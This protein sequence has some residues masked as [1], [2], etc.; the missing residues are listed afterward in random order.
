MHNEFIN[1]GTS[2]I[3]L[4]EECIELN[5]EL[6]DLIKNICKGER[7][8]YDDHSPYLPITETNRKKIIEEMA[9]VENAINN[10]KAF[11]EILPVDIKRR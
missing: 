8:G 6:N 5:M 11:L 2:A 3:K 1:Y 4:I 7:F 10:F 9:D